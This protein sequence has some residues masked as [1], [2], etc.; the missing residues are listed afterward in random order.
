MAR[1]RR[2]A[3]EQR[4]DAVVAKKPGT[5]AKNPPK[6][7]LHPMHQHDGSVPDRPIDWSAN[8]RIREELSQKMLTSL[9]SVLVLP[10]GVG[11]T[12]ASLQAFDAYRQKVGRE[13]PVTVIAPPKVVKDGNWLRAVQA[14]NDQHPDRVIDPV[15]IETPQR[16]MNIMAHDE[17]KKVLNKEMGRHGVFIVDEVHMFA[18]PTSKQTKALGKFPYLRKIGL[19]GTPLTNDPIMDQISYLVLAGKYNSKTAFLRES[20]LD[21][22][23]DQYGRFLVYDKKTNRVNR[24]LWPYYDVMR[25]ELSEIIYSPDVDLSN[26][27]MPDVY[28]HL[29]VVEGDDES[30]ARWRSLMKA[31][32]EGA[33]ESSADY[34]M[35]VT[36][37]LM[38]DE[39]RLDA[40]VEL[41]RRPEAHQP[42]VFFTHRV[43]RDAIAARFEAEGIAFGER[44]GAADTMDLSK[45]DPV[46]VQY[47]SGGT[48]VE[49]PDS[50]M[51]VFYENQFS[52]ILLRQAQGRN[53]RRGREQRVDQYHLVADN[54]FDFKVFDNLQSRGELNQRM[55]DDIL[56]SISE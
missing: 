32:R 48:G 25:E 12:I 18:N 4:A 2:L 7:R 55:L 42:L 44:S 3:A 56:E 19:T 16:L 11:K 21:S 13:V 23:Q 33:F 52:Y 29:R 45:P 36:E 31:K 10:T 1:K 46:L 20:G 28:E 15:M 17:T 47:Q 35:A 50:T 39:R 53:V 27:T 34:L 14:F 38:T 22:L 43:T 26:L 41:V 9:L 51:S 40:L 30:A 54:P 8:A 6:L 5:R 24:R 49:M 37:T